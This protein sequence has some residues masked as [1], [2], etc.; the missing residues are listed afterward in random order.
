MEAELLA[1]SA[2]VALALL[3]ALQRVLGWRLAFLVA[4]VRVGLSLSFFGAW[5]DGGWRLYDDVSYA[6][7][8]A[9]LL[10]STSSPLALVFDPAA[11]ARLFSLAGGQNVGYYVWN[12]LAL[13]LFGEHYWSAVL[14]NVLA[15]GLG[16]VAFWRI[17]RLSGVARARARA[18]TLFF[19]LHWD[20][21]AWSSFVNL[22]DSLVVALSAGL[23]AA[24]LALARERRPRVRDLLL[25][26]ASAGAL[27]FLRWYVPSLFVCAFGLW[28]CFELRGVR[29]GLL[30]TAGLAFLLWQ[31]G[32][33]FE[34]E[35]LEPGGVLAGAGRFLFTP[36]PWAI[37]DPYGFLVVP[38][39]LHWAC[40]PFALWG[41][42]ALARSNSGARLALVYLACV[43]LFYGLVPELQGPRH[44]YQAVFVLAWFQF[45]GLAR[46]AVLLFARPRAAH[47]PSLP[48][49]ALQPS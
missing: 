21:L 1:A 49:T 11:N 7:D 12:A 38:A 8:S 24:A 34:Q 26:V 41:A 18:A 17:L 47:T 31:I 3:L 5:D 46:A 29:R 48:S 44:R 16:G 25:L 27:Y 32:Q 14:L 36:R 39:I 35:Y 20:V 40:A 2:L 28:G 9:E 22:K 19:L 4:C 23:F 15:S 45:E 37:R 10:A 42:L 30:V 33:P 6:Q 43:V 13:A